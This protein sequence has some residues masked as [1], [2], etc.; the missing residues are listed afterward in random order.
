MIVDLGVN[1]VVGKF[2]ATAKAPTN[3]I[4]Y[5]PIFETSTGGHKATPKKYLFI[6]LIAILSIGE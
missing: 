5:C 6:L 4:L 1:C 2:F 3:L